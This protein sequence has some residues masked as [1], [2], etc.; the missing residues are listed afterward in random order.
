MTSNTVWSHATIDGAHL[1][2]AGAAPSAGAGRRRTSRRRPFP[3]GQRRGAP[4]GRAR[5]V[6]PPARAG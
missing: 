5:T 3:G 1:A 4:A 6:Q 2:H